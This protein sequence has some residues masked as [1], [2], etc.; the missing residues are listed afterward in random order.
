MNRESASVG[1]ARATSKRARWH[2]ALVGIAAALAQ[3]SS[4][5]LG[6][7]SDDFGLIVAVKEV[8]PR[9]IPAFFTTS[10]A[11]FYRPLVQVLLLGDLSLWGLKPAGFHLTNIMLHVIAALLVVA[12]ARNAIRDRPAAWLAAGLLFALFPLHTYA[13][14]IVFGHTDALSAPLILGALLLF[15]RGQRRASGPSYV[16]AL[17][18]CGLALT[19]K[20]MAITLPLLALAAMVALPQARRSRA[21]G[22]TAAGM[23]ALVAIWGLV[24]ARVLGTIVGAYGAER[25]LN[26]APRTLF[27]GLERPIY[28]LINPFDLA[29]LS[30]GAL[31]PW[32]RPRLEI[33]LALT[34]LAALWRW[35][36]PAARLALIWTIISLLP[37]V[38]LGAGITEGRLL[39]LPSAF[40]CL[41]P[42][43]LAARAIEHA[44]A[45]ARPRTHAAAAAVLAVMAAAYAAGVWF[46]RPAFERASRITQAVVAQTVAPGVNSQAPTVFAVNVPESVIGAAAVPCLLNAL[47]QAA[48]LAN[49]Q[50]R[51][52]VVIASRVD[53]PDRGRISVSATRGTDPRTLVVEAV[54]PTYFVGAEP[55]VVSDFD[56]GRVTWRG[57]HGGVI[58]WAVAP[59]PGQVV[60]CRF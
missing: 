58:E 37:I 42:A 21:A 33:P 14:S 45:A 6:F 19:A 53:V 46:Q 24:R 48:Y 1:D 8:L 26:L 36:S 54:P 55:G 11:T 41:V 50:W 20:E 5:R 51:A 13:I 28:A 60:I 38:T 18:L 27:Y 25:L 7:L 31:P 17:A 3:A 59:Q 44:S 32:L 2:F 35:W 43:A 47:E 40:F 22:A 29:G 57:R 9:G 23:L 12:L 10:V 15:M 16:G 56:G 30:G 39:Y 4:L 34:A 52:R 49:P